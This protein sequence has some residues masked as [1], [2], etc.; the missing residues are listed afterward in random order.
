MIT[1]R[2][3]LFSQTMRSYATRRDAT[4]ISSQQEV[5]YQPLAGS[6]EFALSKWKLKRRNACFYYL[7]LN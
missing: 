4:A 2:R 1:I 3:A 6:Q 5:V 7:M